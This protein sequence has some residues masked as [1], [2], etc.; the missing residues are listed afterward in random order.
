MLDDNNRMP[1]IDQGIESLQQS[2]DVMEMQ[3][4]RR[5]VKDE[6]RRFLFLL[7][8]IVSSFTRWF[9][10]PDKVDEVWP[11]LMYPNPTSWRGFSFLT[12]FFSCE[13]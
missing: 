10:P 9:S 11:S 6:E 3:A 2:L 8:Q 4:G 12:I 13:P 5:L 1:F 7:A